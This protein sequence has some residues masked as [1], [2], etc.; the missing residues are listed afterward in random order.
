MTLLIDEIA[1]ILNCRVKELRDRLNHPKN[2][3]KIEKELANKNLETTY[4]DRNGFTHNFQFGGITEK[5]AHEVLAYGLLKFPFN[6]SIATHFYA[7]H[8]IRL[9]NPYTHCVIE[10]FLNGEHRY[11]PLELVKIVTPTAYQTANSS[12]ARLAI[13]DD[14]EVFDWGRNMLSQKW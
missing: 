5:G 4:K 11:Y 10:R 13:D 9:E 6:C 1:K 14:N 2:R 3:S 12:T 8:R 7:R